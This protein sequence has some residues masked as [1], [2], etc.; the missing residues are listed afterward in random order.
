MNAKEYWF[1][2]SQQYHKEMLKYSRYIFNDHLMMVGIIF[3]GFC[4]VQYAS[5]INQ[6]IVI[7]PLMIYGLAG[8]MSGLPFIGAL[9]TLIEEADGYFLGMQVREWKKYFIYSFVYSLWLPFVL[10]IVILFILSPLLLK[11]SFITSDKLILLLILVTILKCLDLE[12]ELFSLET[13]KI[14]HIIMNIVQAI[15]TYIIIIA[16]LLSDV[17]VCLVLVVLLSGLM[18]AVF[19]HW[20]HKESLFNWQ[21]IAVSEKVRQDK[22]YRFI[23][24][25]VDTN[26]CK[27]TK[28]HSSVITK[29]FQ[30]YLSLENDS[31]SNYLFSRT[32][33]RVDAYN[34]FFGKFTAMIIICSFGI[35]SVSLYLLFL[36]ICLTIEAIYISSLANYH[37]NHLLMKILNLSTTKTSNTIIRIIIR[38]LLI[39]EIICLIVIVKYIFSWIYLLYIVALN[40]Y[41]LIFVKFFIFKRMNKKR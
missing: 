18:I 11:F 21:R 40:I 32:L 20:Y 4:A 22:W 29:V 10:N 17:R 16:S 30:R 39:Q 24:L 12:K 19:Y 35:S 14:K 38:C 37:E 15:V 23:E 36:A 2:R 1:R 7:S 31:P 33:T 41:L 5:F 6:L 26:N 34:R 13:A 27:K 9:V 28:I 3:L 25:F 8:C